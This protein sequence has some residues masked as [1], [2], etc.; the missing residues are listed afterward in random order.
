[1]PNSIADAAV[2]LSLMREA[3]GLLDGPEHAGVATHLQHAINALSL[4]RAQKPSPFGGAE[5]PGEA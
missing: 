2:A 1:M 4:E 5:E 3:L